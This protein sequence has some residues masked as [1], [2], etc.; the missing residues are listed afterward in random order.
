MDGPL[1]LEILETHLRLLLTGL[2]AQ[3]AAIAHSDPRYAAGIRWV[4][5]MLEHDL[6]GRQKV[7]E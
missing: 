2:R 6:L 3:A 4:A 1:A 5:Q 7:G